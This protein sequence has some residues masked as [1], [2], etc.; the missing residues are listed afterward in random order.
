MKKE[1]F[2]N[3]QKLLSTDYE[4]VYPAT[5]EIIKEKLF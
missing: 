3:N 1:K 2:N 4:L 5:T